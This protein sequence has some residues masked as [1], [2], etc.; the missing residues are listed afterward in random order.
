MMLLKLPLKPLSYNQYYRNTRS[1]NRVKTGAGLAY[2][3]EIEYILRNYSDELKSFGEICDPSKN[4]VAMSIRYYNPGMLI[5]DKSRLS[6]T[7]G[8]LDNIVKVLQDKL[9]ALIGVDD[10]ITRSLKV[11]DMPSDSYLVVV[12]LSLEPIP[13]FCPSGL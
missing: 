11:L 8:D 6:K 10:S 13:D 12:E 4:I 1:G 7:A 2:D 9:F 5:K 3:E